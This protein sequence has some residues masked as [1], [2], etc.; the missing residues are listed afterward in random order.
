M[1]NRDNTWHQDREAM[2]QGHWSGIVGRGNAYE[3]FVIQ[4]S[5]GP[6]VDRSK[7]HLGRC[8]LV[9]LRAQGML[10][11]AIEAFEAEGKL[12]FAGEDVDFARI[13]AISVAYPRGGDWKE[14]D[15]F[16][17]PSLEVA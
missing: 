2:K 9:I 1:G 6:V 17:L 10:L 15:A 16:N 13:R 8:D 4:E 14:I 11:R 3:D 5:M 7:Q 12:S